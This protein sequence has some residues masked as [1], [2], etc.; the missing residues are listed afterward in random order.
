MRQALQRY[1]H[2]LC[3]D[4][5]YNSWQEVF[6]PQILHLFFSE[7]AAECCLIFLLSVNWTHAVRLKLTARKTLKV[8]L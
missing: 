4:D 3:A 1:S 5:S 6:S 8:W 7:V 2:I